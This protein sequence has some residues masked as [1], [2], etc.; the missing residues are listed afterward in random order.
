MTTGSV[1]L[2]HSV[3][4]AV[5]LLTPRHERQFLSENSR[6]GAG[7]QRYTEKLGGLL[8]TK[9]YIVLQL[10]RVNHVNAYGLRKGNATHATSGTTCPHPIPTVSRRGE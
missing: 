6:E 4:T 3:C 10:V 2:L 9:K 1:S 8:D 7:S 5:F